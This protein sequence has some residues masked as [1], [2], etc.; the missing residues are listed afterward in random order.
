MLSSQFENVLLEYKQDITVKKMG[1]PLIQRFMA[2][3]DNDPS[4]LTPKT[5]KLVDA[6]QDIEL[7]PLFAK[8]DPDKPAPTEKELAK[9]K[10]KLAILKNQ[11]AV[12]ILTKLEET[13]PTKNKNY[14]QWLVRTYSK[15]TMP[16]EDVVST[17][18]DYLDKFHKLKIKRH[19]KDADI[20]QYNNFEDFMNEIDT[21]PNDLIDDDEGKKKQYNAEKIYDENGIL[22]IHPLDKEASCR[23]GR[24]T[25]WCTASTRG[26]NYFDSYNRKGPLYMLIPRRPN[27][28]GE[29]YQFH[30]E[31]GVV[32]DEKDDY[33]SEPQKYKLA[34]DF[35]AIKDAF[36][37]QAEKFG[38]LWL[39][40]PKRTFD[41]SNFKVE[42]YVKN[43]APY[44]LFKPTDTEEIFGME[45]DDDGS[46]KVSKVT[47]N[48]YDS[49]LSTIEEHD[50]FNKY[51][52]LVTKFG[53][54]G[55]NIISDPTITNTKNKASIEQHKNVIVMTDK[56]GHKTSVKATSGRDNVPN[57]EA[58]RTN[59]LAE[60]G[61]GGN[62]LPLN[63]YELTLEHPELIDIYGAVI[64][65]KIKDQSKV[66]KDNGGDIKEYNQNALRKTAA[67]LPYKLYKKND[68]VI[69]SHQTSDGKPVMDY[70]VSTKDG[71]ATI[72]NRD[73]RTGEVDSVE[74]VRT[75]SLREITGGGGNNALVNAQGEEY[76]DMGD[77]AFQ[78]LYSGIDDRRNGQGSLDFLP[79][80]SFLEQHPGLKDFYKDTELAT[81]KIKEMPSGTIKDYG[82]VQTPKNSNSYYSQNDI[83]DNVKSMRNYI[84]APKDAKDGESY[85]ISWSPERPQYAEVYHSDSNGRQTKLEEYKD[86]QHI[87]RMFPEIRK[88]QMKDW[89][90]FRK[91]E[92]E[93]QPTKF[94]HY[95]SHRNGSGVPAWTFA[96]EEEVDNNRVD[97]KQYGDADQTHTLPMFEVRPKETNPFGE[98][99]DTFFI[100]FSL[101]DQRGKY[102]KI[103]EIAITKHPKN[104]YKNE[105]VDEYGNYEDKIHGAPSQRDSDNEFIP[106]A[107]KLRDQKTKL[108][109]KEIIDFFKYYP[110][111]RKMVRD[112]N[113]HPKTPH[114]ALAAKPDEEGNV[115]ENVEQFD[116]FKLETS[117]KTVPGVDKQYVIPNEEEYPGE[118]YTLFT[119]NP[120][121]QQVAN[122]DSVFTENGRMR[123]YSDRGFTQLVRGEG[124]SSRSYYGQQKTPG[125]E[126]E[127][128]FGGRIQGSMTPNTP[129]YNALMQR[130]PALKDLITEKAIEVGDI[131]T[132]N[133]TE[134]DV[135]EFGT[136]RLYTFKNQDNSDVYIITPVDNPVRGQ[137]G[138][139]KQTSLGS[140]DSG[141]MGTDVGSS[142]RKLASDEEG[143]DEESETWNRNSYSVNFESTE[144]NPYLKV[145]LLIDPLKDIIEVQVRA[146]GG[147]NEEGDYS[148]SKEEF[149][150]AVITSFSTVSANTDSRSSNTNNDTYL[151]RAKQNPELYKWLQDKAEIRNNET[152]GI[153]QF[154]NFLP[155]T[156]DQLTDEQKEMPKVYGI[157]LIGI[158]K[159]G[160]S[161]PLYMWQGREEGFSG[162]EYKLNDK[163]SQYSLNNK[164]YKEAIADMRGIETDQTHTFRKMNQYKMN[165][166][167]ILIKPESTSRFLSVGSGGGRSGVAAGEY[168]EV[169]NAKFLNMARELPNIEKIIP[170]KNLKAMGAIPTQTWGPRQVTALSGKPALNNNGKSWIKSIK[171]FKMPDGIGIDSHGYGMDMPSKILPPGT[172]YL[173]TLNPISDKEGKKK[174]VDGRLVRQASPWST[175]MR[176]LRQ[177]GIDLPWEFTHEVLD[178]GEKENFFMI[179]FAND[180]V[181][182]LLDANSARYGKYNLSQDQKKALF[183]DPEVG[184]FPELKPIFDQYSKSNKWL[185]E[186]EFHAIMSQVL[187][188]SLGDKK[189][190]ELQKEKNNPNY[191]RLVFLKNI[192]L[193]GSYDNNKLKEL[194]FFMKNGEWAIQKPLYDKLV[195]SGQLK[196]TSIIRPLLTGKNKIPNVGKKKVQENIWA[197]DAEKAL[198]LLKEPLLRGGGDDDPDLGCDMCGGHGCGAGYDIKDDLARWTEMLNPDAD[199]RPE[200]LT[201]DYIQQKIEKLKAMVKKYP[202]GIPDNIDCSGGMSQQKHRE[203][204]SNKGHDAG[205]VLYNVIGD[206]GLHDALYN[207]DPDEDVR[208]LIM[209]WLNPSWRAEQRK[210]LP[211]YPAVEDVDFAELYKR[212]RQIYNPLTLVKE[213]KKLPRTS[214]FLHVRE[215]EDIKRLSG[216]YDNYQI[217]VHVEGATSAS[218]GSNISQ[219]ASQISKIM[220]EKNIQPGTP[221]WFQLWFSKPYLTGEKPTGDSK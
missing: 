214:E 119:F 104:T 139:I 218:M 185:R 13:D 3:A 125:H 89:E 54:Q 140:S 2:D 110:E 9:E 149:E 144:T 155:I 191:G 134:E 63:P 208:P 80:I 115:E 17:I 161:N 175:L 52:D 113:I 44:Y 166:T 101:K 217:P 176:G 42:E 82:K 12:S 189:Y 127:E 6:I 186:H 190:W 18:A 213:G 98:A 99:G 78:R 40:Q 165:N 29:K 201:N 182:Y 51:P 142:F 23:Y 152:K 159:I 111:L 36:K 221:E 156:T 94:S 8:P 1:E 92:P 150:N 109:S 26:H 95:Q 181:A 72:I 107:T 71:T 11:L 56:H 130:F 67:F 25:R 202:N 133:I 90:A 30:F 53:I 69:K 57:I 47:S 28:T 220:K 199:N 16:L 84:V 45:K 62:T 123:G 106:V 64:Q 118:F 122:G 70:V 114:P 200:H 151:T 180:R 143:Y 183:F 145:P 31:D 210:G 137:H 108:S 160:I 184:I 61:R 117:P 172:G 198:E 126:M 120:T 85:A 148:T 5:K 195:S 177:H 197:F 164:D 24:G 205:D 212:A 20:G 73:M 129:A 203:W 163:K 48:G 97:I 91:R 178:S 211:E 209:N 75:N 15:N 168:M 105:P 219:T 131:R 77:K 7:G 216:V 171:E 88:M 27:Y 93:W 14:V 136:D 46:M 187:R 138:D 19:L 173:I 32:A 4:I 59:P 157:D 207:M 167:T 154:I 34:A 76:G 121:A 146:S 68:V 22:V 43:N 100:T 158:G 37:A 33:L 147:R 50:L 170:K 81:P 188:E 87:L 35:P 153:G 141:R 102:G 79:S 10:E 96:P 49:E 66:V 132:Q 179:Y 21:F 58:L 60:K 194:G 103:S 169:P 215:L 112:E 41:G 193:A 192:R 83:Q 206:D 116:N 124:E 55:G 135:I 162:A 86:Q 196:E 39:Q 74:P 128:A 204:E 174:R 65:K 38:L